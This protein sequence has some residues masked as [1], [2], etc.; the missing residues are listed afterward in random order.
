MFEGRTSL[1]KLKR[2]P[3]ELAAYLFRNQSFPDGCYLMTG[4]GIV[5]DDAFTLRPGD[6][7]SITVGSLPPLVNT[8]NEEIV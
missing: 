8:V 5:P 7:V 1:E 6:L 2:E 3:D 4:T